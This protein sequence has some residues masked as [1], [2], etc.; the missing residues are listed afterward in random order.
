MAYIL[1]LNRIISISSEGIRS[2][3]FQTDQVVDYSVRCLTTNDDTTP[4]GLEKTFLAFAFLI[5]GTVFSILFLVCEII[6]LKINGKLGKFPKVVVPSEAKWD[7][8]FMY[9]YPKR[10]VWYSS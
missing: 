1:F 3:I 5:I 2:R 8:N 4:L 10:K 7:I 6:E 9:P